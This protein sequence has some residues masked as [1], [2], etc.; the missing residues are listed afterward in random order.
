MQLQP[1]QNATAYVPAS[2]PRRGAFPSV[3]TAPEYRV[4]ADWRRSWANQCVMQWL[5]DGA[6]VSSFDWP[7][8]CVYAGSGLSRSRTPVGDRRR[9]DP[10]HI[11][12]FAWC[13]V[14]RAEEQ[15]SDWTCRRVSVPCI[16]SI[17]TSMSI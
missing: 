12:I 16:L 14:V 13:S 7:A 6:R 5:M 17:G 15:Y 1:P 10:L 2:R 9:S 3:A 8:T 11:C 4:V